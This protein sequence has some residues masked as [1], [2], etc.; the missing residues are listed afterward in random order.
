MAA[1]TDAQ[2]VDT[3][4]G[5]SVTW[6][7]I[8][9]PFVLVLTHSLVN[10]VRLH[11]HGVKSVLEVGC[12]AGAG[13]H[14]CNFLKPK[15]VEL[16]AVDIAPAMVERALAKLKDGS[17]SVS[18]GNAEKLSFGDNTFDRYFSSLCLHLIGNPDAMLQEA[19]RVLKRGGVAAFGVWGRREYGSEMT[20]LQQS[21]AELGIHLPS[22]SVRSPFHLGDIDALRKRFTDAG[23]TNVVAWY[24]QCPIPTYSGDEFVARTFKFPQFAEITANLAASDA[25]K[26][27]E[28]VKEKAEAI[29]ASGKPLELEMLIVVARKS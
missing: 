13:T 27:K 14:L 21:A 5:F 28:R 22:P 20:T 25:Q 18:V 3:W 9:E 16:H 4:G 2:L 7:Q 17:V 11:D 8:F 12:G 26:L 10:A 24:Q 29:F 15:H 6:E 23:F 19:L 1:P